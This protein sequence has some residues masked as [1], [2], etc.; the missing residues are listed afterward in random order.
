MPG[1]LLGACWA[2][3]PQGLTLGER[4][5]ETMAQGVRA[6]THLSES[7]ARGVHVSKMA[8]Q[9]QRDLNGVSKNE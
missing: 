3:L 6:A 9:R 8:S 4:C 2:G 1:P 5:Q 7:R